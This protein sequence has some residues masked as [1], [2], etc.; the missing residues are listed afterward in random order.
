[1]RGSNGLKALLVLEE[2]FDGKKRGGRPRRTWTDV[3]I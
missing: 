2:K 1:M 3:V